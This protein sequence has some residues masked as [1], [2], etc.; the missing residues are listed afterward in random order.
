M[1]KYSIFTFEKLYGIMKKSIFIFIVCV[2]SIRCSAQNGIV[3]TN[4]Q[5]I[6]KPKLIVGIIVDQMRYDYLIR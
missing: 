6:Q 1:L 4:E 5:T 3:Q 2:L